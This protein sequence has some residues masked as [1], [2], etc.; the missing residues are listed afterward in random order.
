MKKVEYRNGR[1]YG[2]EELD[3][4]S[5]IAGEIIELGNKDIIDYCLNN[6]PLSSEL[7]GRM[8][9]TLK[10]WDDYE[11]LPEEDIIL[12]IEDLV[13]EISHIF[14]MPIR[15][16]LWLASKEAVEELYDGNEDNISG[17]YV[18]DIILTDLGY[19][20][21]LYGYTEKPM[22]LVKKIK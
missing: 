10:E 7:K 16:A 17:Y 12:M 1:L 21:R 11:E 4:Y 18:S 15:Y 14:H 13:K 6:Y 22:P 20:G 19:D 2:R 8:S 9:E 3:I 5:V